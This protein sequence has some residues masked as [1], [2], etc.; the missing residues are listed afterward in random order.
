MGL[1]IA[2]LSPNLAL[3]PVGMFTVSCG[4]AMFTPNLGASLSA[5]SRS[6]S[7]GIGWAMSAM[8]GVQ[9][10]FPFMAEQVGAVLGPSGIFLCLGVISLS[11]AI[12]F[13]VVLGRGSDGVRVTPAPGQ[14]NGGSA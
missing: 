14:D 3:F 9:V 7:R 12:G 2:G 4:L 11:L 10:I 6:P 1:T 8:F 5:N 13:A